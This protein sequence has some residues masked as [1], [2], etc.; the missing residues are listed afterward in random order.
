MACP[1]QRSQKLP[2]LSSA[3]PSALRGLSKK[4]QGLSRKTQSGRGPGGP[5]HRGMAAR[6]GEPRLLGPLAQKAAAWWLWG[7]ILGGRGPLN[8]RG[9]ASGKQA[10]SSGNQSAAKCSGRPPQGFHGD[11]AGRQ[12]SG[13]AATA[14]VARAGLARDGGR[15]GA[16][17][18]SQAL[19]GTW[20]AGGRTWERAWG[21]GSTTVRKVPRSPGLVAGRGAVSAP[22]R[23]SPAPT[24]HHLGLSPLEGAPVCRGRPPCL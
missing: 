15:G 4:G 2:P 19:P 24:C 17:P 20:Q 16:A 18:R 6:V 7:E 8:F 11:G 22:R 21:C 12:S 9:R 23:L 14:D 10:G 13:K 3:Q 5:G 1:V